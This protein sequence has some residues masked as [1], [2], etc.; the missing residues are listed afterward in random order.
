MTAVATFTPVELIRIA[1]AC[2]DFAGNWYG[3]QQSGFT[4]SRYDC[5]RYITEGHLGYLHDPYKR[6]HTMAEV[7]TA[8]REYL[9]AH[10]EILT[11]GRLSDVQRAERQAARDAEAA[12]LLD[13]AER[14]FDEGRYAEALVLVDRAELASPDLA[15]GEPFPCPVRFDGY[16]RVLAEK[17]GATETSAGR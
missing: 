11:A 1:Q 5:E 16:R 14:E 13:A 4:F 12:G 3:K 15:L 17:L 2:E 9:D 7:W 8:V 10:P 6:R